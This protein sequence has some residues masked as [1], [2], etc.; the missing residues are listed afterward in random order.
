VTAPKARPAEERCGTCAY[1]EAGCAYC[2]LTGAM[3][4]RK[5][6]A[7]RQWTDGKVGEERNR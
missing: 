7:C 3:R 5:D 4:K 1:H 6:K 2:E